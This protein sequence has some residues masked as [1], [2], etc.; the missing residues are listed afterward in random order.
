MKGVR[1]LY[2][3]G[4][5]GMAG[6]IERYAW[7]TAR[8]LREAGARVTWCGDGRPEREQALFLGGFDEALTPDEAFAR[9]DRYDLVALH[10]LPELEILT[11]LR[12]RHGE[13]LVFWAHDHDLYCPRRFYYTPFGRVN[14]HRAYAP[15]RCGL[16]ARLV[17]PRNW[18]NLHSHHTALLKELKG[19]EAVV[20][21]AFMQGNLLKNGFASERIHLI[22]PV[23]PVPSGEAP[24]RPQGAPLRILFLGQLI[25]GKGADLLVEALRQLKCPWRACIAGDGRDKAML[26]G[27]CAQ[28][29]LQDIVEFPGWVNDPERLLGESD[30]LVFPSR[31][32]EPFGLSGAEAQA[33]GLPVVA[34]DVGGVR[35]WLQDGKT[36]FVVPP[37]DTAVL[38]ERLEALAADS[39]L[40]CQLGA[41]GRAFTQQHFTPEKFLK[42]MRGLVSFGA[43]EK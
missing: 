25:R 19:H 24:A 39:A 18:R 21:S 9:K 37:F 15:L 13:R 33:H 23:V 32:Q 1:I 16:C 38:A 35:E 41:D 26:E 12:R 22:H 4:P 27:L 20:L 28:Y 11:E 40:A 3:G 14:C 5:T 30:V 43:R 8:L 10:K 29:G 6:G 34:F 31:W 2:W 42:K 7:Q 17:H 36:G